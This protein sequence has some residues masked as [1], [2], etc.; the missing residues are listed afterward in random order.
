MKLNKNDLG[1][2]EIAYPFDQAFDKAYPYGTTPYQ[3]PNLKIQLDKNEDYAEVYKQLFGDLQLEEEY[4]G[5][6][7][8]LS[9]EIY[10]ITRHIVHFT[11]R[12]NIVKVITRLEEKDLIPDNKKGK[13]L[14]D[15]RER[16]KNP[17][18]YEQNKQTKTLLDWQ[19][20]NLN[21]QENLAELK[22]NLINLLKIALANLKTKSYYKT[23]DIQER[24]AFLK[25]LL[26]EANNDEELLKSIDT[27]KLKF[28]RDELD[29]AHVLLRAGEDVIQK[30]HVDNMLVY[31]RETY[32]NL[33]KS[34]ESFD[35]Y[36]ERGNSF[37]YA[38][39]GDDPKTAYHLLHE[40]ALAS[41]T[42]LGSPEAQFKLG[43]MYRLD[44][45]PK[46]PD[47]KASKDQMAVFY[48]KLAAERGHK[49]AITKLGKMYMLGEGVAE[50]DTRKAIEYFKQAIGNQV[51][52]WECSEA[53]E[54]VLHLVDEKD[55]NAIQYMR[56]KLEYHKQQVFNNLDPIIELV[57]KEGYEKFID[58]AL[59]Y[60]RGKNYVMPSSDFEAANIIHLQQIDHLANSGDTDFQYR[61]RG[62]II[63]KECLRDI[64]LKFAEACDQQKIENEFA[65]LA[66]KYDQRIQQQIENEKPKPKTPDEQMR[67][68][69]AEDNADAVRQLLESN[70]FTTDSLLGG[71]TPL[72]CE[73][74]EHGSLE[75][76]KLLVEKNA[77]TNV[78]GGHISNPLI[79]V[80]ILFGL[81]I[82]PRLERRLA[83]AKL[84][85][86]KGGIDI[87][88]QNDSGYSA[89]HRAAL[90]EFNGMI[91][92]LICRG[93][94]VDKKDALGRTPLNLLIDQHGANTSLD[95]I[96]LLLQK[97]ADINAFDNIGSRPW[98]AAKF[99][100][101][102]K[103]LLE[104]Y[105][106]PEKAKSE[107]EKNS[108]ELEKFAGQLFFPWH[109]Y[110]DSQSSDSDED[111]KNDPTAP[112][113]LPTNTT[114]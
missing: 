24:E 47:Q 46:D 48:Y 110:S 53:F 50:K 71:S 34:C 19:L 100:P 41:N 63:A 105:G 68:A 62:Y 67:E 108:E 78:N 28:N 7:A 97:G 9:Q 5:P 88:A 23:D 26:I 73:A 106:K 8:K 6:Y 3:A 76:V 49:E 22:K 74:A 75:V 66:K 25:K 51:N 61:F 35:F 32:L 27:G 89:L 38:T 81:D 91:E 40:A 33:L 17:E 72:I 59:Q 79:S 99:Y 18:L 2:I 14:L 31:R 15:Y 52:L 102:I 95:T 109:P 94:E 65:D 107:F 82:E 101:E 104:K 54:Y 92:L 58:C 113:S 36:K 20:Q 43:V 56:E 98:S 93:A 114:H 55:E 96:K 42:Y 12:E 90:S 13:K 30:Y 57:K 1:V 39:I 85:L 77:K 83:I 84:L 69:I 70:Q 87:N 103:A 60:K 45:V 10:Y 37:K 16:M 4:S 44:L 86:D 64:Y 29:L 11:Q 80:C 111:P 21:F 112:S